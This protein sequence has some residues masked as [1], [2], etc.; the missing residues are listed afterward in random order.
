MAWQDQGRQ[1]HGWFGH[2]TS[3]ATPV[4]RARRWTADGPPSSRIVRVA[5][6]GKPIPEMGPPYVATDL[7]HWIGKEGSVGDGQCVALVRLA[8][9]APAIA[10]FDADGRYENRKDG[11]SHAAIYLGQDARGVY[12]LDQWMASDGTRVKGVRRVAWEGRPGSTYGVD[13][14]DNYRVVGVASDRVAGRR[15][16]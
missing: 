10:T 2:G 3:A 5:T 16:A 12:V 14:G 7:P 1:S 6:G 9:G 8:T 11:T 4:G 13:N 15:R